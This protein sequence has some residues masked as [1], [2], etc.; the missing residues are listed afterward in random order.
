MYFFHSSL[1]LCIVLLT[2]TF[3][4]QAKTVM[5]KEQVAEVEI[6][7]ERK[8]TG[9]IKDAEAKNFYQPFKKPYDVQIQ[10]MQQI[11]K[12]I[13]G[14]Y[15]IGIFESP[16]GTGKTLSL[17]CSTMCWLRQY[18][19]MEQNA[20]LKRKLSDKGGKEEDDDDEPAWV[21]KAYEEKIVGRIIEDAR[22]YEKHLEQLE[23]EGARMITANL[24]DSRRNR[25]GKGRGNVRLT[26]RRR[27]QLMTGNESTDLDDLAPED[28]TEQGPSAEASTK[29]TSSISSQYSKVEQ[30][31]KSLLEKV[32]KR[33]AL[34]RQGNNERTNMVNESPIK[35]FFASRTHSQ[36]SQLSSQ[37]RMTDF[38]SSISGVHEKIKY[39][40]LGSRK[41]L[42]INEDVLKLKDAQLMN[43]KCMAMQRFGG[44]SSSREKKE[45]SK[46]EEGPCPFMVKRAVPFEAELMD[47]F[48]DLGFSDVHDIEDLGSIGEGLKTCP[49]YSVREGIPIAEIISLPYQLLLQKETRDSL[50]I[51]LKDSIVIIDEAHNLMDTVSNMNSSSVSFGEI[52]LVRKAI[53]LYTKRFFSRMNAGNRINLSKLYKLLSLVGKFIAREIDR[54]RAKPGSEVD[55]NEIFAGTT[56]DLLNIFPLQTY[57]NNSKIAFKLQSYMDKIT[58][59]KRTSAPLLFKVRAFMSSLANTAE[60]GKFFF[61]TEKEAGGSDNS[62]NITL[63]YLLLDPS[64]PFA[65]VVR[66]SRCVLLAGGTMQP[67]SNFTD[68][69]V[70]YVNSSKVN[71]FS[72][73]HIIPDENLEAYTI[74]QV[75]NVAMEF[76]YGSRNRNEVINSLGAALLRIVST[77]PKGVVAFFTSYQYLDRVFE[78]LQRTKTVQK[79]ERFKKVF[80]ESRSTNVDEILREYSSQIS[81]DDKRGAI[82]FSVVG[83]KMSEGI[84][85]SDDMARAVV[86]VGLPYPNIKSGDLIAKSRYI[87]RKSLQHGD[88]ASTAKR[89]AKQLYKDICMRAVNQ[90]V[91][92]AIRN[93]NDYA[94]IFLIDVRYQTDNVKNGLSQWIQKRIVRDCTDLGESITRTANFFKTKNRC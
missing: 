73:N 36:L 53:K 21:Q 49:Y 86:M 18:K 5:Q 74:S 64:E 20:E 44:G 60:S 33:P 17:I 93:I 67:M 3:K 30:E 78:H 32:E 52:K 14:D 24:D 45:K 70:P 6:H 22:R 81:T 71:T 89:K 42:C 34:H 11:Y 62:N 8:H 75:G 61:D 15:K 40:P 28:Y 91:G 85:F 83:G 46:S 79:L 68:F 87:E 29:T 77:V 31:V 4:P 51:H 57:I 92:R 82:L 2:D 48:R 76:T 63:N 54:G 84:N 66:E 26:K 65:D 19:E 72:C 9:K 7:N 1:L 27:Q 37:L 50:G 25:K 55:A 13:D 16:T 58:G 43:E 12:T 56:G 88:T 39:L 35:I 59:S 23:K 38:P 94:V 47:Q 90:S 10:L 80:K 69:L 41:Q